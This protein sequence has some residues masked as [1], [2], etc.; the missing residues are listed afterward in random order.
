MLGECAG[1][2]DAADAARGRPAIDV[3]GL[4]AAARRAGYL[5]AWP[6]SWRGVDAHGAVHREALAGIA[7]DARA[8]IA[9]DAALA[10]ERHRRAQRLGPASP[11]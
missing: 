7:A 6:W 2:G 8:G 1:Q 5:G 10:S 9:A 11:S 4:A 3:R